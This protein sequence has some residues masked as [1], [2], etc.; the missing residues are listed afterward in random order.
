M[1]P[2]ASGGEAPLTFAG[3]PDLIEGIVPVDPAR[4]RD[5]RVYLAMDEGFE[6]VRA[7]TAPAGDQTLVRLAPARAI[8][9]QEVRARVEVGD[10]SYE[11][12]VVPGRQ[13]QLECI[14]GRLDLDVEQPEVDVTLTVVNL[15]NAPAEIPGASAFGLMT[16]GALDT[17]IGAGMLTQDQG[18]DRWGHIADT[19][20]ELH[21]GLVR[22]AVRSG[23]GTLG[24]GATTTL[25]AV[26]RLDIDRLN[27][28]RQ[29]VG[30]W[31][32]ATLKVPVT[33]RRRNPKASPP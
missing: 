28:R 26:F 31:V 27:P 4:R 20:A 11:A 6:P 10:Q 30:T 16:E 32:I 14:P 5:I 18:V 13:A 15:G 25:T 29:F 8:L 23:A 1:T 12:V 22:V 24:A 19:L 3:P 21:G 9:P 17:A 7:L 2:A 33:V